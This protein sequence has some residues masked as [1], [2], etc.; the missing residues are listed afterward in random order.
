MSF[1]K[2]N[3]N[4]SNSALILTKTFGASKDFLKPLPAIKSKKYISLS[5]LIDF[6][7]QK[8][9]KK[10]GISL[11][12]RQAIRDRLLGLT[13]SAEMR[14]KGEKKVIQREVSKTKFNYVRQINVK[15]KDRILYNS[16]INVNQAISNYCTFRKNI[17]K[18]AELESSGKSSHNFNLDII[19]EGQ[20]DKVAEHHKRSVNNDLAFL[21]LKNEGIK[22]T[23]KSAS[24]S[25]KSMREQK[26]AILLES[27]EKMKTI[28]F[29]KKIE[30]ISSDKSKILRKV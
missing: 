14:F 24:E 10:N 1:Y 22:V 8:K 17:M 3:Q 30:E 20:A 18:F 15:N 4:E 28:E 12:E 9:H 6:K 11:E 21:R 16:N 23:A 13:F 2:E 19:Y 7:I 29:S 5:S 26:K 25:L 27:L